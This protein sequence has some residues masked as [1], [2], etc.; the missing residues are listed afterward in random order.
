MRTCSKNLFIFQHTFF[1]EKI[2]VRKLGQ[3]STQT[4]YRGE[5]VINRNFHRFCVTLG[6]VF[7]FLDSIL[8]HFSFLFIISWPQSDNKNDLLS[9]TRLPLVI[10]TCTTAHNF[11]SSSCP[12]FV[13]YYTISFTIHDVLT[14]HFI[15]NN[16]S[17]STQAFE[18]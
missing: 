5:S 6:K 3:N 14:A 17:F 4:T 2:K 15:F 8:P 12:P 1:N 7:I 9:G 18:T 16:P 10:P 11:H 13:R